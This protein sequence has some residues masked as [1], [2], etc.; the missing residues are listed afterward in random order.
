MAICV[1][2]YQKLKSNWEK[3]DMKKVQSQQIIDFLNEK[4]SGARCPLCGNSGW[5]I[6][7]KC[8]ELR[9]FND[10]NLILGG[11]NSSVLP[12]IPVTCKNCGNTV[13]VNALMT[14]LLKE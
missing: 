13:F 2:S 9:E 1:M 4:W 3:K 5:N 8:F 6:T 11:P 14:G 10:G 12:V 7:D